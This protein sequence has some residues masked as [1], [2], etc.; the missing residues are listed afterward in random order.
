MSL[1]FA[2][3]DPGGANVIAAFLHGSPELAT[4]VEPVWTV[5]VSA[6]RFAERGIAAQCFPQDRCEYEAAVA[7]DE[8]PRPRALVTGTSMVVQ[9]EATLWRLAE[10]DAVPSLAWLDQWT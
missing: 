7:W 4:C 6:S 10:A 8:R 1:R 2:A 5:P 9:L 3:A